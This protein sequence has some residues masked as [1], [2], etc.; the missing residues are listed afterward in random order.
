MKQKPTDYRNRSKA[1]QAKARGL[2]RGTAT[3]AGNILET[4]AASMKPFIDAGFKPLPGF[5][6]RY[7]YFIDPTY[8]QRLTV[9]ELPYSAIADAG[10]RM[11]NGD[12]LATR[13][14]GRFDSEPGALD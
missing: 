12:D 7:I 6:L 5:Q 13:E 2:S 3:K 4:G 1:E 9:P 8:R 14:V 10:A 11:Y